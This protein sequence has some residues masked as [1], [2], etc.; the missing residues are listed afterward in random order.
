MSFEKFAALLA[1]GVNQQQALELSGVKEQSHFETLR[2]ALSAGSPAIAAARV[3]AKVQRIESEARDEIE[4]AQQ[5][6]LSTKKLMLWLPWFGLVLAE[7]TGLEVVSAL[8]SPLGFVLLGSAAGLSYLGHRVSERMI[9]AAAETSAPPQQ[10]ILKLAILIQ[11]GI[12]LGEA[13][14]LSEIPKQSELIQFALQSGANL[15]HLLQSQIESD[16]ATWRNR[17]LVAAKQ[18]SVRLMLPLGLTTLPAFLLLTV[19]PILLGALIKEDT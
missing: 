2:M 14:R 8:L 5:V 4:Q 13:L 3:L 15:K 7:L 11:T 18:L 16:L 10:P 19:A 1:A 9:K 6:P 12:Q 17:S